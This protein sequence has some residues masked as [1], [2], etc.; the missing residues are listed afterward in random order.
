MECA[1]YLP[2]APESYVYRLSEQKYSNMFSFKTLAQCTFVQY[3][4]INYTVSLYYS[5]LNDAKLRKLVYKSLDDLKIIK[6]E[7]LINFD[8]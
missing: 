4:Y 2:P 3:V 7:C 8:K 6:F 1:R 5:R